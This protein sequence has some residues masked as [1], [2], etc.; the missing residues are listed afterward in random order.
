MLYND[1]LW[2]NNSFFDSSVY[3][4]GLWLSVELFGGSFMLPREATFA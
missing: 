4:A 3:Q 2:L 1:G